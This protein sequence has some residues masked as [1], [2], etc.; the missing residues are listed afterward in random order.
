MGLQCIYC[1]NN[2]GGADNTNSE[3]DMNESMLLDNLADEAELD[4]NNAEE[5][6]L[7]ETMK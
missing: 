6:K 1:K 2:I 7:N 5:C 4:K 3:V